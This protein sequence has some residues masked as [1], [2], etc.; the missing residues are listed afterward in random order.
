MEQRDR[1]VKT[2]TLTKYLIRTALLAGIGVI[3]LGSIVSYS[4]KLTGTSGLFAI[5]IYG[6]FLGVLISFVNYKRYINP[7]KRLIKH[8][9]KIAQGDL[10]IRM[11]E[12]QAGELKPIATSMNG[13][14]DDL[15]DLIT[16]V[17]NTAKQV[18]AS[19]GELSSVTEEAKE[20]IDYVSTMINQVTVGAGKSVV[21]AQTSSSAIFEISQGLN[22]IAEGTESVAK[23]SEDT[24]S[25]ATKGNE[26]LQQAVGQ[27]ETIN[28]SVYQSKN[29]IEKLGE[30]SNEIGQIV[31]V[32]TNLAGQT[33]LLALNASIEA[34]RTGEHG[35][36]F[37][38]VA[39]EVRKLAVQSHDQAG[40]ISKII[41]IIQED[42][43]TAIEA[44]KTVTDETRAG[45][46][47]V[48]EGGHTFQTI[49]H[50][51]HG[52]SDQIQKISN[53]ISQINKKVSSVTTALKDSEV[54]AHE[55]SE[56]T[57][58]VAATSEE[59]NASLAEISSSAE[60]LSQ[61]AK[62]LET[63]VKMFKI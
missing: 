35:R 60:S 19:S 23:R 39:E 56:G 46:E 62:Q 18:A 8:I 15:R 42:T 16:K 45:T 40:Q 5:I 1:E 27:M 32:M 11:D 63:S 49:V 58:S 52:V 31:N 24:H 61:M 21:G 50:D 51:V 55:T 36:G 12:K 25:Q 59:Q 48:Q 4:D 41:S 17:N 3:P 6:A 33:N 57:K 7:M 26:I 10:T 47:I 53:A 28:S 2:I 30:R 54:I 22:E 20:S 43:K 29:V 9:D 34:A 13:M 14:S 38:V 44:M 37:A